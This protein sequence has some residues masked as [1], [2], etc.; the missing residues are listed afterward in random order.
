MGFRVAVVHYLLMAMVSGVTVAS[1][2][3]VGSILVVAM[4]VVPAATAALLTD[5]LGG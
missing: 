2:E 1:F 3:S 4:L 5:R